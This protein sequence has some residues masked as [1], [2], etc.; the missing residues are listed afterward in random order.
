MYCWEIR[1]RVKTKDAYF[2]QDYWK[3]IL[4]SFFFFLIFLVF[5]FFGFFFLYFFLDFSFFYFFG[6]FPFSIFLDFF[7]PHKDTYL[8]GFT[9]HKLPKVGLILFH[10][11]LPLTV[12]TFNLF[13]IWAYPQMPVLFIFHLGLPLA[14]SSFHFSSRLTSN[15][16]Y[17]FIYH[18]GLPLTA[19]TFS[20]FIWAYL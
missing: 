9:I 2:V 16:L 18:L 7:L 15:Y 3:Q 6:F 1:N 14:A 13:F 5:L 8:I 20:F 17:F 19:S 12:S 10:L 4:F 11:V